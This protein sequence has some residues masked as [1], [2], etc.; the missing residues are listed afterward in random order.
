MKDTRKIFFI[1]L[2]ATL[3]IFSN[4]LV[5]KTINVQHL[6][7]AGS[8][9][10]Y[11]FTFLCS[12]ILTE[13]YGTKTGYK[14]VLFSVIAQLALLSLGT[15]VV[16]LPSTTDAKLAS[17]ALR[18]IIAPVEMNGLYFP[19]IKIL[20][21]SLVAFTLAQIICI[22]IYNY[23]AKNIFKPIACAVTILMAIMIDSLIFI[24]ITNIGVENA[25]IIPQLLNQLIIAVLATFISTIIYSS[26]NKLPEEYID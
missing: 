13:I 22:F 18:T 9:L 20:I 3:L 4:I 24:P 1:I 15:I 17:D 11:P 8:I 12:V 16:N 6:T 7:F 2:L 26:I 10:T 14:T 25:I 23:L 21:T 5:A 19:D